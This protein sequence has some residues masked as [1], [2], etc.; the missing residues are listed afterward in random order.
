MP[1][2]LSPPLPSIDW[3]PRQLPPRVVAQ[4]GHSGMHTLTCSTFIFLCG[5]LPRTV[6]G[7]V[8]CG[9]TFGWDDNVDSDANG[10]P[11]SRIGAGAAPGWMTTPL[12]AEGGVETLYRCARGCGVRADANGSALSTQTRF[13]VPV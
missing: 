7:A 13:R 12:C 5:I 1:R 10:S 8:S 9:A 6:G 3:Y 4:H 11:D 2:A